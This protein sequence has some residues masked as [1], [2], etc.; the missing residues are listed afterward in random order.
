MRPKV[1]KV[2][3]PRPSQR[4]KPNLREGAK[5]TVPGKSGDKSKGNPKGSG[6][7]KDNKKGSE[8]KAKPKAAPKAKS[9]I[10]RLFYPKGT[11]N[12]GDDCPFLHDPKAA[13]DAKAKSSAATAN[14]TVAFV[15]A[16]SS[17]PKASA[18]SNVA[19]QGAL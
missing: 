7:G 17:L 13:P 3:L 18:M 19:V 1:S 11:G 9:T 4:R 16:A 5:G 10:P 8:P 12:R 14:A 15:A 2:L 6:K